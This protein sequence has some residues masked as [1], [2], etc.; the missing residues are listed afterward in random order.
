M[1]SAFVQTFLK[2]SYFDSMALQ[3]VP[4]EG[5]APQQ[6]SGWARAPR[7]YKTAGTSCARVRS[8]STS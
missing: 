7:V 2:A 4:T 3:R 5:T 8:A 6:T 1:G